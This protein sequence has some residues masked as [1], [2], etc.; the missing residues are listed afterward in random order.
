MLA[1]FFT[2]I[3][4]L[5]LYFPSLHWNVSEGRSII[6]LPCLHALALKIENAVNISWK[7]NELMTV[8][9]NLLKYIQNFQALESRCVSKAPIIHE[10]P[11]IAQQDR[12]L[13]QCP[14]ASSSCCICNQ[15]C[16]VS[17]RNWTTHKGSKQIFGRL[18]CQSHCHWLKSN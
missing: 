7:K 6:C 3:S 10:L 15:V 18:I 16:T 4:L 17:C 11:S 2:C 1:C 8:Q 14:W 12:D 5:L 9:K 13:A